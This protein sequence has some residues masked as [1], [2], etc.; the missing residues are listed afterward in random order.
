MRWRDGILSL[1]PIRRAQRLTIRA[2]EEDVRKGR[3]H[4]AHGF[5]GERR[6]VAV[7]HQE[8]EFGT[9]GRVHRDEQVPATASPAVT[10][11]SVPMPSSPGES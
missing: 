7:V 3:E 8:I 10:R 9:G 6:V 4:R 1:A 5:D 11:R 2:V